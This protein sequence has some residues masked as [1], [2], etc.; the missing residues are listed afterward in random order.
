M[1]KTLIIQ[2]KTMKNGV[3]L[4]I[5]STQASTHL[6]AL[7]EAIQNSGCTIQLARLNRVQGSILAYFY[8]KGSWDAVAKLETA[9]KQ[10]QQRHGW[11]FYLHRLEINNDT[12]PPLAYMAQVV[13]TAPFQFINEVISFFSHSGIVITDFTVENYFTRQSQIEMASVQ[14]FLQLPRDINIPELREQFTLLCE[15]LQLDCYFEPDKP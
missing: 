10:L 13:A 8:L 3:I 5:A 15:G 14:V 2:E 4:S 9:L 11:I 12:L 6:P 1:N 7:T